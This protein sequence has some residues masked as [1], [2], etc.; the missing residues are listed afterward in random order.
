MLQE[1]PWKRQQSLVVAGATG[2]SLLLYC[3]LLLG[4]HT[5]NFRTTNIQNFWMHF[6]SIPFSKN[7]KTSIL[8]TVFFSLSIFFFFLGGYGRNLEGKM[9]TLS[10]NRGGI[11]FYPPYFD[12]ST[13]WS[14]TPA[15]QGR[16][17]TERRRF[18]ALT[19]RYYPSRFYPTRF[20]PSRT[21]TTPPYPTR[22]YTTTPFPARNSTTTPYRTRTDTS[23]PYPTRPYRTTLYTPNPSWT[24]AP[25][26]TGE[27]FTSKPRETP[28][29]DRDSQLQ[30]LSVRAELFSHFLLWM[31]QFKKNSST[32]LSLICCVCKIHNA[33]QWI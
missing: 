28:W 19:K 22:T 21:Y 6:E 8:L 5:I 26:T 23:T 15:Y 30:K 3:F 12:S 13:L 7:Q 33:T 1:I 29:R 18:W 20:Y 4:N 24:T 31:I 10:Q 25:T 11:S 32:T 17:Y 16:K 9:F 14:S 27:S 2:V